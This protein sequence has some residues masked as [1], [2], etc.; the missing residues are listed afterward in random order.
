M[1]AFWILLLGAVTDSRAEEVNSLAEAFTQGKAHV[2]FRY[3]YE[4]VDQDG[5]SK[6]ADASTLKTRI[7]FNTATYRGFSVFL[8][9]DD[10]SYIGNEKFNNTR[11]GKTNYP[12]VADP[13]GTDIN[14]AYINLVTEPAN[15]RL[16]RQRINR[17]NQRFVGGVAWRQNEQTFDALS[18]SSSAISSVILSISD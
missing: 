12:T 5:I 1:T 15:F 3:R 16:G 17:D 13:D 18:F 6:D 4:Q 2:N 11:N 7:N 9:A 10:V 8:E 14:Q